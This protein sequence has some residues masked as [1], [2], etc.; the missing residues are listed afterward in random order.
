[1]AGGGVKAGYE[2]GKTDDFSYNIVENPVHEYKG[3]TNHVVK[4]ISDEE[5]EAIFDYFKKRNKAVVAEAQRL[6]L[7]KNTGFRGFRQT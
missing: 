1:M 4:I 7:G 6:Y 2:H 3:K 5:L